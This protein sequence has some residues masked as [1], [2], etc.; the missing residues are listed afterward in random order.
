MTNNDSYTF[1]FLGAANVDRFVSAGDFV[2][3]E[4]LELN[5]PREKILNL[6][7][8][9]FDY[10]IKNIEKEVDYPK[11]WIE[12][13]KDK[14]VAIFS[15][16]LNY[17]VKRNDEKENRV[18]NFC[19]TL[20]EFMR[21][22]QKFQDEDILIIWRPHPLT[23]LYIS[24]LLP[25]FVKWYD[26]LCDKIKGINLRNEEK[27]YYTNIVLD[28]NDSIIPAFKLS[29]AFITNYT[30]IMFPYLMLNKK[31]IQTDDAKLYK[32]EFDVDKYKNQMG[33]IT[34][35][36][37]VKCIDEYINFEKADRLEINTELLSHFYKNLDGTAGEKIH[38]A[39]KNDILNDAKCKQQ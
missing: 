20:S 6:G 4:G 5:I 37:G 32:K 35:D 9:K 31:L 2:L 23:R 15:T 18:T 11:E 19:Y 26:N 1:E 29:D 36:K 14:R 16:S 17:F 13:S 7:S 27:N 28:E 8:P 25:D 21:V 30:S 38:K 33:F 3:K 12:K 10:L 39:V 34:N 24:R 22:I